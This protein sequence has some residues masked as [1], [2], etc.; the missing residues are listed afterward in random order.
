M[1]EYECFDCGEKVNTKQDLMSHKTEKHYKTRLCTYFHGNMRTCRFPAQ[2]CMNI[3]NENIH[4]TAAPASDYRSRISCKH[5]NSCYF[6]KRPL[7]CFYK[8]ASNVETEPNIWQQRSTAITNTQ[9]RPG[10]VQ[11]VDINQ[12]PGGNSPDIS[13][14]DMNQIVLNMSKQMESIVQKLQVLEMKSLS[15]FPNLEGSQRRN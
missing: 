8:H 7:G 10:N 12:R 15:D 11:P 5:G 9:R 4:P 14:V 13:P 6:R 2:Q 1:E 3:H